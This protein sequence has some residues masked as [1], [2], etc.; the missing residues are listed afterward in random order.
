LSSVWALSLGSVPAAGCQPGHDALSSRLP[1]D[2]GSGAELPASPNSSAEAR[3]E[4]DRT[5]QA[6]AFALLEAAAARTGLAAPTPLPVVVQPRAR[7]AARAL[8]ETR[9]DLPPAA[10]GAYGAL[11]RVLELAPPDFDYLI[12]LD[13]LLAA[14]TLALY[15]PTAQQIALSAGLSPERERRVLAHELAHLLQDHHFQLDRRLA[16]P[17]LS[18]D[19]RAAVLGLVEGAASVLAEE[20]APAS[21]T[22][23]GEEGTDA[24]LS[25]AGD[26]A[27][28][29][30][31]EPQ[32]NPGWPPVLTR[33]LD[34]TYADG[35]ALVRSLVQSEGWSAVHGLL[36][37]PP[38]STE[39]LLHPDKRAEREPPLLVAI[40]APPDPS[41]A[42]AYVDTL[43]E[44]TL[45][46]V[47]EEALSPDAAAAA[48]RG[49]GGDRLA[50]FRR[51]DGTAL[52]WHLVFDDAEAAQRLAEAARESWLSALDPPAGVHGWC[53]PQRDGG[54]LGAWQQANDVVLLALDT[55]DTAASDTAASDTAASATAVQS[56]CAGRLEAWAMALAPGASTRVGTASPVAVDPAAR[57]PR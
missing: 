17:R 5:R 13:R 34:A 18:H 21:A 6:N 30:A 3:P 44:Q 20:L 12:G 27:M 33:S 57:R 51:G 37:D 39:Q 48:T 52:A 19:E 16:D 56:E 1:D 38:R 10:P 45:R 28:S 7:V 24:T 31:L 11:L 2:L 36:A 40:P 50:L 55:R 41:W 35:Q 25:P 22:G 14:R 49:W 15:E 4:P 42:V 9:R 46:S 43:G 26:T 8:A 23:G 29:E 54:V 47:L 32:R 53:R